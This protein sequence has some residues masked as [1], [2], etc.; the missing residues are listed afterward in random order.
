MTKYPIW[1]IVKFYWWRN[2]LISLI[3]FLYNFSAYSFGIFASTWLV[4]VLPSDAPLWKSF[5]WSTLINLFWVPGAFLGA[6]LSDWIGAKT[7]LIVGVSHHLS[8]I[9]AQNGVANIHR[10]D[11]NP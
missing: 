8:S 4:F 5:G 3:W 2:L 1:L 11:Y 6:F 9:L 7:T 10:L